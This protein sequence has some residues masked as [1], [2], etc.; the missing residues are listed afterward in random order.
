MKSIS[1]LEISL[2]HFFTETHTAVCEE[3][4]ALVLSRTLQTALLRCA[5]SHWERGRIQ[6]AGRLPQFYK[7]GCAFLFSCGGQLGSQE[8]LPC[9]DLSCV[10]SCLGSSE[11]AHSIL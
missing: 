2:L 1:E 5:S 8:A 7:Q 9:L 3:H 10:N 6:D 11:G 4:D